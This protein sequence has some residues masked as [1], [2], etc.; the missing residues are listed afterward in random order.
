[1]TENETH[2][3][4]KAGKCYMILQLSHQRRQ[5]L[6]EIGPLMVCRQQEDKVH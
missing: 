6:P 4:K 1:M 2:T 5:N 3:T